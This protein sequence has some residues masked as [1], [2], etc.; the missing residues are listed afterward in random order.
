M[1]S[2]LEPM[3]RGGHC[4]LQG[5]EIGETL[6][7]KFGPF[8]QMPHPFIGIEIG[9]IGWEPFQMETM[10]RSLGQKRFDGLTPMDGGPIPNEAETAWN[11]IE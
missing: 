3:H 6:V 10:G 8:E 5:Q 7:G 2:G 9:C 11:R 4:G 1:R